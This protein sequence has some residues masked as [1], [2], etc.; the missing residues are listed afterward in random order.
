MQIWDVEHSADCHA[1][2][3]TFREHA[4]LG[5][6]SCGAV[7]RALSAPDIPQRLYDS[8]INFSICCFWDDGFTV[9]LGDDMNGFCAETQVRTF[10]DALTWLDQEARKQYPTSL[11]ATGKYPEGWRA[12]G[13]VSAISAPDTP[14][15]Q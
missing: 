3:S 15:N 9:K 4:S 8:E 6:C 1:H 10:A 5:D 7:I 14:A 2:D 13:E 12:D 11:Y